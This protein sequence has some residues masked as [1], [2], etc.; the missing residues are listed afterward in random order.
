[1]KKKI[2]QEWVELAKELHKPVRKHFERRK[3]ITKGINELWAADLLIMTTVSVK[4]NRGYKYMLNVIDTFS[5]FAW[6]EPLKKKDGKSVAEAFSKIIKKSSK[7][8]KLLHTDAGKEFINKDFQ[9]VLDKYDIKMYQTFS[10]IKS[11]IVERFNRTIN[12]KL[13]VRFEIN[14]NDIWIDE[15]DS[16]LKEYNYKDFHRTIGMKPCE[17][18]EKNEK[19]IL[20]RMFPPK[21]FTEKPVFRIGEKVRI[22]AYKKIFDNKYKNNWT[23]EIFIVDKIYFTEPITYSIHDLNNEQIM[24]KFYRYELQKT[25]F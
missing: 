3:I 15:I 22:H 11:S 18:S 20:E 9:G 7:P 24:G 19:E 25:K 16:I 6:I 21:K 14:Q 2:D 23:N 5:K 4:K 13:K 8:P 1:M 10:E 17:V 12:E